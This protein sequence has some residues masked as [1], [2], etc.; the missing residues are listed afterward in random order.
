MNSLRIIFIAILT[1]ATLPTMAA[2]NIDQLVKKQL[3]A[4][5][6][7]Q[8]KQPSTLKSSL[9]TASHSTTQASATQ[10]PNAAHNPYAFVLFF[11]ST[12]PHCQR[13][14]PILKR[15][16]AAHHFHVYAFTLDGKGLPSYPQPIPAVPT[17]R[18]TFFG[19]NPIETPSLFLVNVNTNNAMPVS[20]GEMSEQELNTVMTPLIEELKQKGEY[21]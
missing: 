18:Q 10:K 17:I 5:V 21:A 9:P 6:S 7:S 11:S 16:A 15:W 8:A 2:N 1:L 3:A 19:P 12:C 4:E 13:F 14:A 20:Q